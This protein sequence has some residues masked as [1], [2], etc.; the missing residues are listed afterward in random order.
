M[1]YQEK[2]IIVGV[3]FSCDRWDVGV[4]ISA[5]AGAFMYASTVGVQS[6]LPAFPI[7]LSRSKFMWCS[8]DNSEEEYYVGV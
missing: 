6:F 8:T 2:N 3:T 7:S 5:C 1:S 4:N